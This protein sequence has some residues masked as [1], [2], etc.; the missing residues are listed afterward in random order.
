MNNIQHYES[1][2][3][4]KVLDIKKHQ[5][6]S[7]NKNYHRHLDFYAISQQAK[8]YIYMIY[9]QKVQQRSD[10]ETKEDYVNIYHEAMQGIPS[11][12]NLIKKHIENFVIENGYRDTDF[13]DYY[14]SLTDALFEEE[15]GWGPLS[16]YRFEENC[17]GAQVLGLDIKFK[18]SW[19]WELQP[20]RFQNLEKVY[21]VADRFSNMDQRNR[22]N[23]HTNPELETKTHDHIR[24]SI[25]IPER[26]HME[27]VITLR[28]KVIRNLSFENLANYG[29][30]PKVAI[31]LFE[32]LARFQMNSVIAGPPGCGKS[33]FLQ[34]ILHYACYEERDGKRVPERLNTVFAESYPEFDVREMHPKS[35]ILHLIGRGEEFEEII[36]ASIL[37]HDIS[38]VVLGEIREHEVGLYRR[39][40][41]QG[42]KQVM[43]TLH[44]LDP[45]DI[46]EIM[47]NLYLQYYSTGVDATRIYKTFAQNLHF[48]ISM[49]EFLLES[50][51]HETL[52]KR[53]TGIHLYDVDRESDQIKL[54]TIMEYNAEKRTWSF[55]SAL[56]DRF[57]RLASKYNVRAFN[58]FKTVLEA[59]EQ[60]ELVGV[61]G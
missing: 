37:R 61:G 7:A 42:I 45:I 40:S 20:Y 18:R 41:L 1:P 35:N 55:N 36:M 49:D 58:H 47:G 32:T 23:S 11:S 24:V 21:E 26:M 33:T 13:P 22:L 59:L 15:F 3:K 53:V 16:A 46:P 10:G 12:V 29:T 52:A 51:G 34:T 5:P 48:A 44:D 8:D 25:M 50:E 38:R 43:G 9:D 27:P 19:G 54:Y 2:S 30:F 60:T 39:A 6:Q 28:K 57:V 17:E 14:R 4:R 56:P 31:P